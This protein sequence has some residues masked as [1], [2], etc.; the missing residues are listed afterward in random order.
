MLLESIFCSDSFINQ[1]SI[2]VDHDPTSN[3][4]T[5]EQEKINEKTTEGVPNTQSKIIEDNNNK[6]KEM[7][8][9]A[10]KILLPSG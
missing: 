7:D 6:P 9:D 8:K 2:K 1:E 5:G 3:L 4:K 10:K